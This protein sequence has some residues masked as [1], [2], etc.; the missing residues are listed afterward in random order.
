MPVRA[1]LAILCA[2]LTLVPGAI[3]ASAPSRVTASDV[4]ARVKYVFVL[5]QENRSFDSYFG[6]FP[7]ASGLFSQAPN[8]TPGFV[9]P[10]IDT[11]GKTIAI[12][13][14]RIGPREHAADT[15]DV[16]HSHAGLVAKMHVVGPSAMMDHFAMVEESKHVA[17]GA[18]PSRVAK[19]YGELTMAY[20]D[21]DTV[22]LLWQYAHN[23]VLFDDIFQSM[24]GPSTPGNLAII[25]AQT[26]ETQLAIHPSLAYI[27]NGS[28]GPGLPVVDDTDPLWG[29]PNDTSA[30][31]HAPVNPG[32]FP[33]YGIQDNLTFATLPLTLA[34]KSLAD[35]LRSDAD[36]EFDLSD[37]A[38]D[39]KTIEARGAPPI[40]WGWY[41]EGY[42]REPTDSGPLTADGSHAS[43]VTHHNGPQYFGYLANNS[44]ERA[45]MHGLADFFTALSAGSLSPDGALLYLKGGYRNIAGLRPSFGDGHVQRNFL[46]DDDHPAYSD[47]QISEA[48]VAREI[49]AIVR[50]KYW[51]QSAIVL[52]WDDSEGDYDHVPPPLRTVGPDGSYLADGPRVPLLLISPY[53]KT[54]AIEHGYGDTGSVVKFAESV[55]DRGAMADLPNEANARNLGRREFGRGDLGPDDGLLSGSSDLLEA[56]DY[57]RLIGRRAPV[58]VAEAAVADRFVTALPEATGMNCASLGIVPTDRSRPVRNV[59]PSDFNPRPSTDPG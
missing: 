8:Q 31:P 47:A 15:D 36:P 29:S 46:G 44:R 33:G 34:G 58:S 24:A 2:S 22:P 38:D 39:V 17:A 40:S 42:D 50:S 41:E 37:V 13:P 56:F 4:R 19:E 49:N 12:S 21:C 9:Q 20:E 45:N 57:D 53:A 23:F 48:L 7:G 27:G 54:G 18:T 28:R 1:G 32:D 3:G 10:L 30:L 51:A 16:D 43:Y 26:G 6:T 59:V 55:F 11:D 52:T 25:G 35:V 14:F 5:Y